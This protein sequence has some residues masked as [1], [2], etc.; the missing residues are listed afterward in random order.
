MASAGRS[1][2][3]N[4]RTRSPRSDSCRLAS[5]SSSRTCVDRDLL[6]VP[7]R[8]RAAVDDDVGRALHADEVGFVEDAPGDPVGAVVE[9]RHELVLGVERHR[10]PPGQRPAGL[11][12]VD[13]DLG[14]QHHEGRFGRV[15]DDRLVVGD[16]GVA[17]QHEPE[18]QSG[19]VRRRRA[20]GAED[21]AGLLVAA[22]FDLVPVAA[23]RASSSPSWRSS[24]ACRS[25]RC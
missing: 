3:A 5:S 18:R 19:E 23:G 20:G 15:A 6:A 10:R 25:C 4:A 1:R 8:R 17:A 7:Q 12:G 2:T 24:S 22:A 21:G 14:G 9:R 13:A 11:L 16:G